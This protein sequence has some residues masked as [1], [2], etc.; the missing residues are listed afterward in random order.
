[1]IRKINRAKEE[2]L[3]EGK[4]PTKLQFEIKAVVRNKTSRES[5]KVQRAINVALEELRNL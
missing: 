2:F 5:E 1:M 3:R 4:I